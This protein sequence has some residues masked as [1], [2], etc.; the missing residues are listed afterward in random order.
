MKRL[1]SELID[2]ESHFFD[3]DSKTGIAHMKLHFDSPS[4]LFEENSVT[5]IPVFKDDFLE[6]IDFVME[7]TPKKTK[8]Q[9]EVTFSD[10]GGYTK[11]EIERIFYANLGLEFKKNFREARGKNV[12]AFS[13]MGIGAL[14]FIAYF[15]MSLLWT[16]GGIAS[17]MVKYITDSATCV[18]FWEALTILVVENKER[19]DGVKRLMKRFHSISFSLSPENVEKGEEKK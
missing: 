8:I 1:P 13:L 6:W 3:I 9:L 15:V 19:R 11:E 17:E 2:I 14:F 12:L 4:D 7:Y 16:E 10:W 5:K 18:V